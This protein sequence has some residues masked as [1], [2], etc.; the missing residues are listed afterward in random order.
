MSLK[1]IDELENNVRMKLKAKAQRLR[2]YSKRSSQ[3]QQNKLFVD[4]Q[5]NVYREIN[6]D[7]IEVRNKPDPLKWINFGGKNWKKK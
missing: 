4:D 5:K 2:R 7:Q 1:Q 6:K 3:F